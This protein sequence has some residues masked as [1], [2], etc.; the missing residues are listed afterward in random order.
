MAYGDKRDYRKIN[1]F[2]RDGNGA[3]RYKR[4]TTWSSSLMEARQKYANEYD[5]HISNVKAEY[6]KRATKER[7]HG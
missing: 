4:S 7:Q 6:D 5:V 1:L 3:F 2:L